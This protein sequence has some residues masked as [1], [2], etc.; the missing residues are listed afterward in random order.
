VEGDSKIFVATGPQFDDRRPKRII[1]YFD[2]SRL[3]SNH[4]CTRCRNLVK[5]ESVTP[6]FKT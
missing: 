3:I 2:F 4:F 1:L 6:E 5:F